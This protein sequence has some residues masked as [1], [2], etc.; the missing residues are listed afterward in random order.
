MSP[1]RRSAGRTAWLSLKWAGLIALGWA[2]YH[3]AS[4]AL[5]PAGRPYLM[6]V[7]TLASLGL[8]LAVLALGEWREA[9]EGR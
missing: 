7:A 2:S 6:H 8:A 3:W 4:A 1:R 9:R 5:S